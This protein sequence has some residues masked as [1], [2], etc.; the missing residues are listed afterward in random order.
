MD[1]GASLSLA[2]RASRSKRKNRTS[3]LGG[4]KAGDGKDQGSALIHKSV[5][6]SHVVFRADNS[7][8][9]SSQIGNSKS[10]LPAG[11]KLPGASSSL[12]RKVAGKTQ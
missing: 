10:N 12:F 5:A 1:K 11:G 2:L 7:R 4:N 9:V 8:S 6:L 3:F